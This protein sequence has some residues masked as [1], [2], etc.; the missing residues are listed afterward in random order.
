MERTTIQFSGSFQQLA[1]AIVCRHPAGQ[2][3]DKQFRKAGN[4]MLRI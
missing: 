4:C 3:R 1:L 2:W